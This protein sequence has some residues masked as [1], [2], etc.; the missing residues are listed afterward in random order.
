MCVRSS[1]KNYLSKLNEMFSFENGV[2]FYGMWKGYLEHPDTKE[3]VD[4]MT[5]KG[6][7]L[8]ILHTSGHADSMTID[9]LINDVKPK[10]IIPVHTENPQWFEKYKSICISVPQNH[11]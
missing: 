8:H 7:K 6:A 1:M 2:L 10:K 5:S 9:K 11:N 4:F 3:F